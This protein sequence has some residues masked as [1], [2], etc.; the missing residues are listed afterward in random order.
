MSLQHDAVAFPLARGDGRWRLATM[1]AGKRAVDVLAALA[2][3]PLLAALIVVV[4]LL[5][6][7]KNPGPLFF[8]QRRMGRDCVPFTIVKFR[9]MLPAGGGRGHDD[10]LE[11][12]RITA[13][14]AFLRRTRLDEVPQVVNIL[15]GE[16]SLVGPRPDAYEH[17]VRYVGLIPGYRERHAVRPGITG[18]AQIALGYAEGVDATKRKVEADLAYI[19]DMSFRLEAVILRRTVGVILTGFGAR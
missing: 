13:F 7:R 17:A 10:P 19:R 12:E 5:N 4:A 8:T 9:T 16:M 11:V 3:L 1:R 15:R 18:L 6:L 2:G 14:G